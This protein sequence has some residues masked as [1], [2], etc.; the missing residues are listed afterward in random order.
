MVS[1]FLPHPLSLAEH[2][3]GHTSGIALGVLD[4]EDG[5]AK[6]EHVAGQDLTRQFQIFAFV[7]MAPAGPSTAG[8]PN[9]KASDC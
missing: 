9:S 2:T 7:S 3:P 4:G 8:T 1:H 5:A 6:V